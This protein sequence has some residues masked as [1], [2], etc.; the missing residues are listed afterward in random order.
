[1]AV[2]V[3]ERERPKTQEEIKEDIARFK[4]YVKKEFEEDGLKDILQGLQ[5]CITANVNPCLE[6][7]V[8]SE[9]YIKI[10]K[11]SDYRN[12][13]TLDKLDIE[14]MEEFL[15]EC[16]EELQDMKKSFKE[17]NPFYEDQ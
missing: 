14:H 7:I 16:E 1:M 11:T 10:L 4:G 13:K 5:A 8:C 9:E 15:K 2:A 12:D 17:D 6:I 3:M